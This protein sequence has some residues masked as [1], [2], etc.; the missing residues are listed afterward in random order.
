[1]KEAEIKS[2]IGSKSCMFSKLCVG[3]R[4]LRKFCHLMSEFSS[5]YL[6]ELDFFFLFIN[7]DFEKLIYVVSVICLLTASEFFFSFFF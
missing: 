4:T 6:T 7:V 2:R 3:D 1:M 5:R